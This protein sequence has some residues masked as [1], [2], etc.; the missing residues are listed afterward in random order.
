M[1]KTKEVPDEKEQSSP[2]KGPDSFE[3][4]LRKLDSKHGG[5]WTT[6]NPELT[7]TTAKKHMSMSIV[8]LDETTTLTIE[9]LKLVR[10][11]RKKVPRPDARMQHS[12]CPLKLFENIHITHKE[13][14]PELTKLLSISLKSHSV[15]AYLDA[16]QL[17]DIITRFSYCEVKQ[18][19]YVFKQGNDASCFFIVESGALSVLI[20]G[21]EKNRMK[22]GFCFGE[23][24][25]LYNAPRSASVKAEEDSKLWYI[26]RMTFRQKVADTITRHIDEN[27]TFISKV[28]L[29]ASMTPEQQTSIANSLITLKYQKGQYIVHEDD[30]ADCCYII[31]EG[32]TKV[33][34]KGKDVG[35]FKS[36]D[37]F[38][39]SALIDY[40]AVRQNSIVAIGDTVLLAIGRDQLQNLL[41]DRIQ[42]VVYRNVQ[43]W[44]MEK[45]QIMQK[46]TRIQIE[47]V[48]DEMVIR[49]YHKGQ[50]VIEN[51]TCCNKLII[52][53]EGSIIN[54][55]GV[56]VVAP[57]GDIFGVDFLLLNSNNF[58]DFRFVTNLVMGEH[59]ILSEI[60]FDNF[61]QIIGGPLELVF[62]R[63]ERS[64]EKKLSGT[65]SEKNIPDIPL[66]RLIFVKKIGEGNFGNVYLVADTD[67][68]LYALK[69]ISRQKIQQMGL[70]K[71]LIAEKKI[72]EILF[73]PFIVEFVRSYKDGR[74]IFFLIEFVRG[75]ELWEVMRDIGYL[76]KYESQFYIGSMILAIEYL[77][78]QSIVHRDIKPENVMVDQSG[79]I[80]LIDMGACKCLRT[81]SLGA[82][83]R[84]FT[85][86]GTPI[87]MAPEIISGK[88][89]T[90][91]VDLWSVGIM[92]YEFMCGMVPFGEGLED[93]YE[94]YEE[95]L[96]KKVSYPINLDPQAKLIMDQLLSR[97][98]EKRLG[99]SFAT[100]KS[101]PFFSDF[102]WDRLMDK[103]LEPPYMPTDDS[104]LSHEEV[105]MAMQTNL[106]AFE[107]IMSATPKFNKQKTHTDFTTAMYEWDQDF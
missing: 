44:A 67:N 4:K 41:G 52:V 59:G 51:G 50:V 45:N 95:I 43:R 53:L 6:L 61:Q 87:Y 91:Q 25:L 68:K 14:T 102:D 58:N 11:Q 94:I 85:V 48:L 42:N 29:F 34:K 32:T 65:K 74:N 89:Y 26:D 75:M 72:H 71:H 39:E 69:A 98:P 38:G 90:L 97:N 19:E 56:Q 16:E 79:Y 15:F 92:L 10:Q 104:V 54:N 73:F 46:L 27:A 93:A 103:A 1:E 99:G 80:K 35:L 12:L 63:N 101:N 83:S 33:T 60:E 30:P 37:A 88:G 55:D 49:K 40:G 64:H 3:R 47:K 84:T 81:S 57:K 77:H 66:E 28:T 5:H 24:A 100:L 9:P 23:L 13:K 76:N 21:K 78:L 22:E 70:E 105:E 107:E 82:V 18:G 7:F 20:N 96:F 2:M 62:Q 17:S 86:I 106:S 8:D 36:G 31:K